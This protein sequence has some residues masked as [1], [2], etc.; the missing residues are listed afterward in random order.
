LKGEITMGFLEVLTTVFIVL[1]LTGVIDWSWFLV[2]L[3]EIIAVGL[4]V[5]WFICVTILMSR[6]GGK[7]K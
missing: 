2:L 4:Y 5:F 7:S 3:P 6:I 1:K